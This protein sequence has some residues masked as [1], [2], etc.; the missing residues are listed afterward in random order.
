MTKLY[1]GLLL[2]GACIMYGADQL[3]TRDL[4]EPVEGT[5]LL[6][7]RAQ[8]GTNQLQVDDEDEASA[9]QDFPL[10]EAEIKAVAEVDQKLGAAMKTD[11]QGA[12]ISTW[13][14]AVMAMEEPQLIVALTTLAYHRGDNAFARLVLAIDNKELVNRILAFDYP[15]G[16]ERVRRPNCQ[17]GYVLYNFKGSQNTLVSANAIFNRQGQTTFRNY[18]C[19]DADGCSRYLSVSS[20]E[21]KNKNIKGLASAHCGQ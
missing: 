17:S 10:S 15:E 7:H 18:E 16:S 9:Q 19:P 21:P 2:S 5:W 8:Q 6:V 11:Q 3:S 1:F 14:K 4:V 12:T 20:N 13:K